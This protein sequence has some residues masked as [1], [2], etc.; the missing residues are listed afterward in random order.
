MMAWLTQN[1]PIGKNYLVAQQH[2]EQ[3]NTLLMEHLVAPFQAGRKHNLWGELAEQLPQIGKRLGW[4]PTKIPALFL[5][6]TVENEIA[7]AAA[8]AENLLQ[9]SGRHFEIANFLLNRLNLMYLAQRHPLFLS[10]GETKIVWLL[11]QWVKQPDYLVIGYL[12]SSLF[13]SKVNE[14]IKFML[15][16]TS[17]MPSHPV[18]ILGYQ[19]DQID[20]CQQLFSHHDWQVVLNLPDW[21]T[22]IR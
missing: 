17:R 4:V 6:D 19:T 22:A 13:A 12:P 7:D 18:I 1:F 11:T 15:E 14:L 20:W 21:R 2:K 3:I 8:T 9:P 5:T 10:D 16:E